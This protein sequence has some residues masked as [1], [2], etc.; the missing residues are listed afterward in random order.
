MKIIART[1]LSFLMISA[2]L[3][4]ESDYGP[5]N[6][7]NRPDVPLLFTNATT[8]GFDPYIEISESGDGQIEFVL[9]IPEETGHRNKFLQFLSYFY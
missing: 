1:I 7:D 6:R 5:F 4:C 3:S 9:E 2:F 8:F